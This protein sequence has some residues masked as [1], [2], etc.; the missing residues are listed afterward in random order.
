MAFVLRIG[1]ADQILGRISRIDLSAL[2]GAILVVLSLVPVQAARWRCVIQALH[3]DLPFPI[4]SIAV[5][6]SYFFNQTLPSSIGGDAFRVWKAHDAGLP[7][8]KAVSSVVLDRVVAL[9]GIVLLVGVSLHWTFNL[10][11]GQAQ[12]AGLAIALGAALAGILLILNLRHF[13]QRLM[14]W[15]WMHAIP[16]LAE[17]LRRLLL[18]P[19]HGV[20]ALSLAVLSHLALAT[21]CFWIGTGLQVEVS[22][23]DCLLLIP[24]VILVSMIPASIAGWGVREGAM[25][26]ALG[27]AHVPVSDALSISLVFGVV[28]LLSGIPGGVVWLVAERSVSR[29]DLGG[30]EKSDAPHGP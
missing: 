9:I 28:L 16:Q 1:N 17:G 11:P 10:I 20:P 30:I 4:A 7:L 18:E 2:A 6:T 22:L 29:P 3:G 27:F 13:P 5:L 14:R 25:I 24:P 12:R 26:V 19:R 8:A 15:R 21:V 23:F